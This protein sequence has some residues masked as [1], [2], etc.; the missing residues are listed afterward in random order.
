MPIYEYK[1]GDCGQVTDIIRPMSKR[2]HQ[3]VCKF[4]CSLN[5]KRLVSLTS[6]ALSGEGWAK[7][8]YAKKE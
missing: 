1:C 6:F 2:D 7:D 5:T 8:G 4:C 3:V